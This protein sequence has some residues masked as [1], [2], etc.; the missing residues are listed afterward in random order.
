MSWLSVLP[1]EIMDDMLLPYVTPPKTEYHEYV[2]CSNSGKYSEYVLDVITSQGY[3]FSYRIPCDSRSITFITSECSRY[4][5]L[6]NSTILDLFNCLYYEWCTWVRVQ[7][8]PHS[9]DDDIVFQPH[10]RIPRTQGADGLCLITENYT[11]IVSWLMRV[12]K[13]M[14]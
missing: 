12:A 10:I 14:L 6:D 3:V 8:D 11:P 4:K 9:Q 2:S 5:I 13:R 1:R 7:P